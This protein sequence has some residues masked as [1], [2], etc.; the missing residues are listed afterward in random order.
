MRYCYFFLCA[1]LCGLFSCAA[2]APPHFTA[3]K[4]PNDVEIERLTNRLKMGIKGHHHVLEL[5]RLFREAQMT[6]VQQIDSL[7]DSDLAGEN[8]PYINAAHRRIKTR[9][10]LVAPLLP[11]RSR[12]GHEA[13]LPMVGEMLQKERESR[14]AAANYLYDRAAKLI[15]IAVENQSKK[16]ARQAFY[17]LDDLKK[18]FYPH[19]RSM[20]SL[21]SRAKAV[22]TAYVLAKKETGRPLFDADYSHEGNWVVLHSAPKEGYQ[23]DYEARYREVNISVGAENTSSSSNTETKQVQCGEEIEKD[24]SG[25]EIKRT[26]IYREETTTTYSCTTDRRA[27]GSV[28]VE[29]IDVVRNDTLLSQFVYGAHSFSESGTSTMMSSCPSAPSHVGMENHVIDNLRWN[30]VVE[31]KKRVGE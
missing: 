13:A 25:R 4:D 12:K 2:P 9:Q 28:W 1:T 6:D 17:E 27:D 11:L 5:E 30:L 20:D 21:R 14:R 15:A 26:P 10:E 23:Y 31:I 16:P 22:G 24:S 7:R 3:V 8:L 19:W 18:H 29:L